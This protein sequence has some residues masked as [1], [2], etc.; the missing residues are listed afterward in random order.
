MNCTVLARGIN[1]YPHPDFG[2]DYFIATYHLSDKESFV[3]FGATMSLAVTDLE[4][5]I[6]IAGI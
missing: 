1:D 6:E 3:G 5:L 4:G 2:A